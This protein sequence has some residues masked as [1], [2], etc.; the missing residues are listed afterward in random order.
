MKEQTVA[1]PLRLFDRLK[2]LAAVL[3]SIHE[4]VVI[5]DLNRRIVY[6][7]PAAERMLG[8]AREEMA[9]NSSVRFFEDVLGNPPHLADYVAQKA[10]SIGWEGEVFNRHK[11]G[12]IFPVH[13]IV[14]P[15]FDR[16]GAVVGYVGIS[17]EITKLKEL[18]EIRRKETERIEAEVR[19]RTEELARATDELAA[20]QARLDAILSGLAEG[21]VVINR[22]YI[23]EYMNRMLRERYGDQVGKNCHLAF[24][25][26]KTPCPVCGV[27]AVNEEGKSFFRYENVDRENR[28]YEMVA[29]PL[30]DSSGRGLVI[31][32]SRDI[33][34]RKKIDKLV[35]EKNLQLTE[36][37]QELKKLLRVKSE[38]LSL[39]SHELKSPLTVV[40]G[41]LNL[42]QNKQLGSLGPEQEEGL[43][44]ASA[45]AEHLEYLINQFLD[46]AQL[47]SG[48]YELV[49]E[50]FD[51]R[52]LIK[53]CLLAL[54]EAADK[55]KIR[56]KVAVGKEASHIYADPNKIKQVFRN[57]IE[58]AIKFSPSGGKVVVTGA[59]KTGFALFTVEDEGVGIPPE[60]QERVFERFYQVSSPL[61][62][63]YGGLG[64]GLTIVK[65]IVNLHGGE[66]W[67]QSVPAKGTKAC[68][69]LPLEEKS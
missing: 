4:S 38:F 40:K 46:I 32:I 29:T 16:A 64:L 28:F 25:G 15:V 6:V 65:N 50:R 1:I 24:Y 51:V 5:T 14:S 37:N 35:R 61:T 57:L 63:K 30:R 23:V 48:R 43:R 9:E 56:F 31:E 10:D 36:M 2:Q 13:L 8:Y 47:D 52:T 68:F 26:R 42:L 41:Y 49:K 33:T 45:E 20:Q 7:N 44:V 39:I 19:K 58:N 3:E 69:T 17:N 55:Q 53:A 34:E 27:K 60:E 62:M 54:K 66:T 11:D 59:R 21:V 22:D 18:E 67:L 12:R